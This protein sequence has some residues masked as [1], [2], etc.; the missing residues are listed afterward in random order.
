MAWNCAGDK[1]NTTRSNRYLV[2]GAPRWCDKGNSRQRIRREVEVISDTSGHWVG[3]MG[4]V[5]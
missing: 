3:A 2:T 5:K 1:G 4:A